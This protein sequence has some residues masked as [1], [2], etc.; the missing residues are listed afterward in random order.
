M[1]KNIKYDDSLVEIINDLINAV[2]S[3][4]N[5]INKYNSAIDNFNNGSFGYLGKAKDN[6]ELLRSGLTTQLD[7]LAQFY[8]ITAQNVNMAYESMIA[9]DKEISRRLKM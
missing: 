7:K 2:S 9:L 4:E 6:T 1:S 3:I 5:C 8:A